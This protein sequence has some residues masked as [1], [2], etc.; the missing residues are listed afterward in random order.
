MFIVIYIFIKFLSH[1][2]EMRIVHFVKTSTSKVLVSCS[3]L[4]LTSY[5]TSRAAFVVYCTSV[6]KISLLYKYT[7]N[8]FSV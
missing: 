2:V 4:M 8:Q 5:C 7:L 1:K 6:H 3:D